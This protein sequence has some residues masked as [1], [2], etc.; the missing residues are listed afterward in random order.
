MGIG[1]S[2][3]EVMQP[4][5]EV[6]HSHPSSAMVKKDWSYNSNP[7]THLHGRKRNNMNIYKLQQSVSQNYFLDVTLIPITQH[8][9]LQQFVSKHFSSYNISLNHIIFTYDTDGIIS[10]LHD[11]IF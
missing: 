7:P 8:F 1:L 9:N 4:E 5:H 3:P 10:S 2:F 6:N 11:T